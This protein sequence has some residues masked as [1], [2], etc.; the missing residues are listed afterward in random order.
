MALAY[1]MGRNAGDLALVSIDSTGFSNAATV[2][3]LDRLQVVQC[4]VTFPISPVQ[5][6]LIFRFDCR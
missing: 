1:R 2:A 3:A 6:T 4:K 5:V